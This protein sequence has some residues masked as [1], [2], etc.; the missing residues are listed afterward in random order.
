MILQRLVK[1]IDRLHWLW[2]LLAVPLLLFPSP[3]RS[4]A[5]LLIPLTW[6]VGWL[7]RPS[8]PLSSSPLNGAVLLLMVMVL[9][10]VLVTPD[11][12]YSLPKVA[13]MVLGVGVF[14]AVAREASRPR[15]LILGMLLLIGAGVAIAIVGLLS[16]SSTNTI[17]AI[18]PI[19][20]RLQPYLVSLTSTRSGLNANQVAGALLWV[21]P[22]ASCLLV[23]TGHRVLQQQHGSGAVSKRL[24]RLTVVITVLL[25]L[26]IMLLALAYTGS[27]GSFIALVITTAVVIWIIAPARWR[28]IGVLFIAILALVTVWH[29]G[30]NTIADWLLAG[31][32]PASSGDALPKTLESRV[33]I[34]SRAIY[35]IEDFPFT[36]TGMNMFRRIVHVLYPLFLIAPDTDL[37]HAHNEFLQVALDLGLPGLIAFCALYVGAAWMLYR[38]WAAPIANGFARVLTLGIGGALFAHMLYGM[39]DAVALGAKPAVLFWLLLGLTCGLFE[40]YHSPQR[41]VIPR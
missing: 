14:F 10:S 13:G 29:V 30:P 23:W 11:L 9:V 21:V 2:L 19:S 39:T 16:A 3:A 40:Q 20:A 18:A 34:W 26:V 35:A 27:R 15:G 4:L 36:G 17:G 6:F 1:S 38:V 28:V 22:V 37:G 32:V 25:C 31:G 5:L 24:G 12:L 33:E 8:A 7:A 41:V